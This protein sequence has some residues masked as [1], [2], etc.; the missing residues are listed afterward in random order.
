MSTQSSDSNDAF[1]TGSSHTGDGPIPIARQVGQ[2]QYLS[3]V[4]NQ[5]DALLG[6]SEIAP[7]HDE[8]LHQAPAAETTA[9]RGNKMDAFFE[10]AAAEERAAKQAAEQAH[11]EASPETTDSSQPQVYAAQSP[12]PDAHDSLTQSGFESH[13]EPGFDPELSHTYHSDSP[14]AQ[15]LGGLHKDDNDHE[16]FPSAPYVPPLD[17]PPTERRPTGSAGLTAGL[18]AAGMGNWGARL[19]SEST[20][21]AEQSD[22][23]ELPDTPDTHEEIP[24]DAAPP[25]LPQVPPSTAAPSFSAHSF[26]LEAARLEEAPGPVFSQDF[27]PREPSPEERLADRLRRENLV[28]AESPE[29][30]DAG[31]PP[32]E[33]VSQSIHTGTGH[34]DAAVP[35]VT[36][37]EAPSPVSSIEALQQNNPPHV[38][39]TMSPQSSIGFHASDG[40]VDLGVEIPQQ[41]TA[42][43]PVAPSNISVNRRESIPEQPQAPLEMLTASGLPLP[44]I[45]PQPQQPGSSAG[46]EMH[47]SPPED[48][49][50][51]M[52]QLRAET[53]LSAATSLPQPTAEGFAQAGQPVDP[54][55]LEAERLEQ[56]FR[57]R[58]RQEQENSQT[59]RAERERFE[60]E[61]IAAEKAKVE[62]LQLRRTEELQ[63]IEQ[64]AENE[65]IAAMQQA[66][67]VKQAREKAEQTARENRSAQNTVTPAVVLTDNRADLRQ[68]IESTP[69][70]LVTPKDVQFTDQPTLIQPGTL[71][72]DIPSVDLP[73]PTEGEQVA[74]RPVSGHQFQFDLFYTCML[75]HLSDGVIFVD[76]QQRVK[77]WSRGAEKMTGIIPGVVLDRPLLPQTINLCDTDGNGLQL[78]ACP[79]AESLRTLSIITGEYKISNKTNQNGLKVELT[80][81]PVI[82]KNRYVNGAV[83]MFHDRSAQVNLQRQLKD[84]YEF[85]VLDPLTQ[86][87]N[88]AEF[89]RV[90]QE[91]VLAFQQSDNF[92]CSIII[93]DI[94]YFKSIND[95]FGHAVGDQALVSFAEMLKR[96]VRSQDL[97]ARYGGEEFVI[98]CADCDTASAVQRAE[99]IRMALY[100][101]PQPMLEGK[102]ISASFGVSELREGDT[103]MDF[104]VRA[105]TALLK[106]KETGRNR[107]VAG[108]GT[109]SIR[110]EELETELSAS[111]VQWK[112][113]RRENTSLICEEFQTETPIQ[114]LV[115]KLRGFIIEKDAILQRVEPEFLSMEIESEDPA[116]YSRKGVFTMNIEFKEAEAAIADSNRTK[117]LNFIRVTIYAGRMRKWF[118][119]NHTDIAPYL[120]GELRRYLMISDK[121]SRISVDLAT[122]NVR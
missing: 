45:I 12:A 55:I 5:K 104:F 68:P 79:V 76:H 29:V 109:G 65:K 41:P 110:A 71:R 38:T 31:P 118:S 84:L 122:E 111:G 57:E 106:A 21:N 60:Q 53:S 92:N 19:A 66:E 80:A 51:E 7:Q 102:S 113:Q 13:P 18:A 89:E 105:D 35:P 96:Y 16:D 4:Q 82:D 11:L 23:S 85:S 88:R 2:Q 98:L 74:K 86:V 83:V 77:M 49:I 37:N 26:D 54:R 43:A 47:Q 52:D 93:C 22:L 103:S 117:K 39:P 14:H 6:A 91:Y 3:N 72:S 17:I 107:V 100:K 44:T 34:A 58:Q 9:P 94:D 90:Q 63:E 42:A 40:A 115:E 62:H 70:P 75:E 87:A 25:V 114:V 24:Y 67:R 8:E 99:E 121:A 30:E 81:I 112:T 48:Q 28:R 10:Q 116:D 108:D 59:E 50:R 120:L 56:Q 33:S 64:Q 101:T 46:F 15:N 36:A 61:R 78:D 27:D 1:S 32:T 69:Q 119:T 95:K 20:L 97:V 73:A